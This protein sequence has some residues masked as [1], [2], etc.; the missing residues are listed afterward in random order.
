MYI[1]LATILRLY[2]R[3]KIQN[4][5]KKDSGQKFFRD[6]ETKRFATWLSQVCFRICELFSF[7]QRYNGVCVRYEEGGIRIYEFHVGERNEER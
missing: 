5:N 7:E 6:F 3:E 4:V 2:V 1:Y